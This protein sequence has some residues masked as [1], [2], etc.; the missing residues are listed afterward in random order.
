[1]SKNLEWHGRESANADELAEVS[2]YG[3]GAWQD[4]E[5]LQR[6][7]YQKRMWSLVL[8]TGKKESKL[9]KSEENKMK[10]SLTFQHNTA[11]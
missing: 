6:T 11:W 2:P 1:M 7:G 8:V 9:M 10:A 4:D 3:N 5:H